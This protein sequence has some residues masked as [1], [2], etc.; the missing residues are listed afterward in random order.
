[1]PQKYEIKSAFAEIQDSF[2]D[3]R[4]GESTPLMLLG[5]TCLSEKITKK[6]KENCLGEKKSRKMAKQIDFNLRW[7]TIHGM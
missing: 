5:E 2:I 1:M 3:A 7:Q 6:W 4:R